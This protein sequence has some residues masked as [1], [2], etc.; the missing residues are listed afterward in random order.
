MKCEKKIGNIAGAK[1]EGRDKNT[2]CG[3]LK[4]SKIPAPG[5]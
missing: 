1:Q 3:K 2:S 5:T 4:N